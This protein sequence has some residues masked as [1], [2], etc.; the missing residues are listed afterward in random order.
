MKVLKGIKQNISLKDYTTFKIG[1]KTKYFT[2][3]KTQNQ[4]I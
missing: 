3:I 2:E 4:L 1:G